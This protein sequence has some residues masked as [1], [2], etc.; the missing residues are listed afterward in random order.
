MLRWRK[1]FIT[2]AMS[3]AIVG[4]VASVYSV[5]T[6]YDPNAHSFCS[7][8]ETFNCDVVNKSVYSEFLGIPVSVVGIG[9]YV[10]LLVGLMYY[11]TKKDM[12]WLDAVVIASIIGVLFSAYLTYIEAYVLYTWCLVCLSSQTAMLLLAL[13][14]GAVRY[15]DRNPDPFIHE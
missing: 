11:H 3:A 8:N 9:G 2:I 10:F 4:I 15:I 7:I 6:H 14:S 13:S 1:L 5:K 12:R